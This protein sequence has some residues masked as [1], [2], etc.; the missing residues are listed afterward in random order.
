MR[1]L[2]LTL[3]TALLS[4]TPEAPAPP[5]PVEAPKPHL[6]P[7]AKAGELP[8]DS[9]DM[10]PVLVGATTRA[11]ILAHRDLFRDNTA[12]AEISP[13][14][15]KRW[16]DLSTPCILVAAFGS[17][18]GDSQRELPDLLALEAEESPFV[19][20]HHLGVYRDKKTEAAAWPQGIEPQ[21]VLKVPTFF[22]FVQQ[23]GGGYKLV[24]SIV[25][26]P[27]KSGQRMAEAILEMLEQ[28]K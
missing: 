20:V 7:A 21:T 16:A 8:C 2:L 13:D 17:W 4:Q 10:K 27:P 9:K 19:K 3:S 6:V 11:A 14:W 24:D 23:P 22:L 1:L 18:C 5:K 26:N 25:E 28:A 12:K 15:R